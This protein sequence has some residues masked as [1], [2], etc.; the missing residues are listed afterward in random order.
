MFI[1]IDQKT[2]APVI[3]D[4]IKAAR[5]VLALLNLLFILSPSFV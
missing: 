3:T 2:T 5:K 4:D 1:D